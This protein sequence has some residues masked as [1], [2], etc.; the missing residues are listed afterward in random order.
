MIRVKTSREDRTKM[1]RKMH[2]SFEKRL[3]GL[4]LVWWNSLS[5]KAQYSVLFRWISHKRAVKADGSR[6]RVPKIKHFLNSYK[7]N[8]NPT[9]VNYRE[10]LID[11]I[12]KK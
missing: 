6:K 1:Y 10:S 5:L 7:K 3:I 2:N 11:Y 8:Y 12:V 9:L 4:D